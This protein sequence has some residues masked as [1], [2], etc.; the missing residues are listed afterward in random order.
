MTYDN[1]VLAAYNYPPH[2]VV[3]GVAFYAIHAE[4]GM[5]E[6]QIQWNHIIITK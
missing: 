3:G 4:N 2:D 1:N 5:I 6:M